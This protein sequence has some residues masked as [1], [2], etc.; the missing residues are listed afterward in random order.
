MKTG[1]TYTANTQL[2]PGYYQLRAV[3]REEGTGNL[4]AVGA[5]TGG[6]LGGG[7]APTDGTLAGGADG[8]EIDGVPD[9][10]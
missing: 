5:L 6:V 3:V 4:G 2:P 10:T 8:V 1:L 7:S 9:G